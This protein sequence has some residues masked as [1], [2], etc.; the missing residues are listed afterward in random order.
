[1]KDFKVGDVVKS[2]VNFFDIKYIIVKVNK[3]TVWCKVHY[4]DCSTKMV[5]GKLILHT[6]LYKNV[7]KSI[8][9]KI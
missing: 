6:P 3:T 7:K 5:G 2:K 1:M 4:D 9:Y 8:L